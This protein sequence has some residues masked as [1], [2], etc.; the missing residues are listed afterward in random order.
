MRF[1]T[2]VVSANGTGCSVTQRRLLFVLVTVRQD[3]FCSICLVRNGW[4]IPVLQAF[5]ATL[6]VRPWP[7]WFDAIAVGIACLVFRFPR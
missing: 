3:G 1:S 6:A 2:F 7:G 4:V 5:C